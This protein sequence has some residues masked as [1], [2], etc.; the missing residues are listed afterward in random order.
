MTSTILFYSYIYNDGTN[1]SSFCRFRLLLGES[2][3]TEDSDEIIRRKAYKKGVLA[4]PG[5]SFMFN[6]APTPY[7]RAAF[8]L[9]EP[10]VVDEALR[11]LRE[12]LLEEREVHLP[13]AGNESTGS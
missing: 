5:K 13:G 6:G 3:G 10:E 1:H 7:V 11:R 12:V 8:S 9:L 4:L 2:T